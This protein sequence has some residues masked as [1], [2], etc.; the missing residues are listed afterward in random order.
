MFNKRK[1]NA[2]KMMMDNVDDGAHHHEAEANELEIQ[3]RAGRAS[4]NIFA[5]GCATGAEEGVAGGRYGR[6]NQC[7]YSLES[8]AGRI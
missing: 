1:K 4:Q 2:S 8:M 5:V 6:D 7:K 3:R